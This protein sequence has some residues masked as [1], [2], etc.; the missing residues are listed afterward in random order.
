MKVVIPA[1]LRRVELEPAGGAERIRR[2]AI[3]FAPHHDARVVVTA[4][5]P[6]S[7]AHPEPVT[8]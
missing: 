6:A 4:K 8:A 1:I 7:A 3:T 5:H 2:R